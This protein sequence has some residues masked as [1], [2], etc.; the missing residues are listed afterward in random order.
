MGVVYRCEHSSTGQAAAVKTVKLGTEVQL[1]ALRREVHALARLRHPGVVRILDEGVHEKNPWYAMEFVDGTP[2]RDWCRL[3]SK[4]RPGESG[5]RS[6]LTLFRRLCSALD[7][8][9][10]EDIVHRD[11]KPE[12]VIVR[13]DGTPVLLDFGLA[14][15]FEGRLSLVL[16]QDTA[17]LRGTLLYMAP[18]TIGGSVADAR[19]DLYALGCMLYEAIAGR[20]PF[21]G[22]V[23]EVMLGHYEG[24]PPPLASLAPG[25]PK[26]LYDLVERLLRKRPAERLGYASDLGTSLVSLGAAN[27]GSRTP[28]ARAYVYR[29]GFSGRDAIVSALREQLGPARGGI[30]LV[31]G[32]SGVGKTRLLHEI[33][34]GDLERDAITSEC[35]PG[36]NQALGALRP[37]LR[38]VC[39]RARSLGPV[40]TRAWLADHGPV[41]AQI[42]PDF[43]DLPGLDGLPVPPPSSGAAAVARLYRALL[44]AI[45]VLGASGPVLLVIDDLQWADELSMGFIQLVADERR[46]ERSSVA[47]LA[48]Y[49]SEETND[50]LVALLDGA[51]VTGL[52]LDRLGADVVTAIVGEMLAMPSPPGSLCMQLADASEGNPFFVGEYLRM[53]VATGVL[54]RGPDGWQTSA[55]DADLPPLPL[56]SSLRALIEA[57]LADLDHEGVTVLSAAAVLGRE[58]DVM[59]LQELVALPEREYY[60]ALSD[61]LARHVLDEPTPGRLRFHHDKLR[62]VSYDKI[63]T[64]A[65]SALH[66]RAAALLEMRID[67]TEASARE[68]EREALAPTLA[69]HF[70]LAENPERAV[71]Y[72][73]LAGDSKLRAYAFG[74]S[75][76]HY[77]RA[78][79]LADSLPRNDVS[80]ALRIDLR[81]EVYQPRLQGNSAADDGILTACLDA[82]P[83]AMR[84]GD[85]ARLATLYGGLAGTHFARANYDACI[86]YGRKSLAHAQRDPTRYA[87][88]GMVMSVAALEAGRFTVIEEVGPPMLDQ[89]EAEDAQSAALGAPYPPYPTLAGSVAV[90]RALQGRFAES[91]SLLERAIDAATAHK[92]ALALAHILAAWAWEPRGDGDRVVV[93]A[94]QALDLATE[95]ALSGP[96]F[97]AMYCAGVG[98]AL[99]GRTEQARAGLERALALSEELEYAAFRTEALYGLALA[100][101]AE[102]NSLACSEASERGLELCAAGERKLE[103][104]FQRL[105]AE[106]AEG[107]EALQRADASVAVA[108]ERGMTVYAARAHR[109]RGMLRADRR[110]SDARSDLQTAEEIFSSIGLMREAATAGATL[111][112][113][114]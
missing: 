59:L 105:L 65:R 77:E 113:L 8:I 3:E 27:D 86:E 5:L 100:Y 90:A 74:E 57:R 15:Q 88:A 76:A 97:M 44:G 36:A 1:G 34:V 45:E 81:L 84:L 49:R 75:I 83:I 26:L 70:R 73:R 19:V 55:E 46:W 51:G 109:T 94:Q 22:A 110:Q 96:R 38:V 66:G 71:D 39:D 102:R 108:T 103:S 29:A 10:G 11:L 99:A 17:D 2:M 62:E 79:E 33:L 106:C 30:V 80:D 20:P 107:G 21:V 12:N 7:Y 104:E 31:G 114:G 91:D 68:R 47:L 24:T 78:I 32:E 72:E 89:I 87:F 58:S 41:L 50:E 53:A 67:A 37:V 63:E 60:R 4:T 93:H 14:A 101:R 98:H 25:F 61:L 13:R 95:A 69:T 111:K 64:D 54:T 9:H 112:R 6:V 52:H 18:E 92:Y 42:V 56:P 28:Q 85:E 40:Q 23:A 16:S 82:E 48:A 43:A 35:A